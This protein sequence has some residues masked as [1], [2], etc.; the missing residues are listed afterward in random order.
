MNNREKKQS[1]KDMLKEALKESDAR[2]VHEFNPKSG[3]IK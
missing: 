2:L 3:E 1:L